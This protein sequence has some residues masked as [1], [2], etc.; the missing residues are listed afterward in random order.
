M[1]MKK[2]VS[3][4][5]CGIKNVKHDVP[6]VANLIKIVLFYAYWCTFLYSGLLYIIKLRQDNTPY[7]LQSCVSYALSLIVP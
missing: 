4:I 3:T 6:A 5:P 7:M 2:A 1:I